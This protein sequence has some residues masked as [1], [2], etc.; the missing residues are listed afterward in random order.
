MIRFHQSAEGIAIMTRTS[1]EIPQKEHNE[2]RMRRARS[3]LA[4]SRNVESDEEK[5]IC[6]W[7]AFNAA[8]GG[9]A[10]TQNGY[11]DRERFTNFLEDIIVCDK[12][13]EIE[14]ILWETYSGPIRVLL[15]NQYVYAP[16]WEWV[17]DPT[18][19]NDWRR[20]F[21]RINERI[22]RAL[23]QRDVH[24]VFTEVFWRLYQLRNQVFHGGVTFK[25][26]WGRTQL[27]DGSRIMAD[28]VPVI[29]KIMEENP[30]ADWG[31]VAYP[32]VG[33]NPD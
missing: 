1:D 27:R 20:R 26:G 21:N 9:E 3:W 13:K 11:P 29:L 2:H 8:Y 28:T 15:T 4:Q 31:K 10:T 23:G 19:D 30:E 12:E 6:L 17:R 22:K 5:F 32:R 14:N 33:E 25:K 24:G 7:I 18:T 16:F